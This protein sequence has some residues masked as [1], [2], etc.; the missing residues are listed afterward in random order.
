MDGGDIAALQPEVL[1]GRIH[2]EVG[3]QMI[4]FT[5]EALPGDAESLPGIEIPTD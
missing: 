2:L 1:E 5:I 4:E 3:E